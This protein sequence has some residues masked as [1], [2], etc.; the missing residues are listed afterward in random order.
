M[1]TTFS[2]SSAAIEDG[3]AYE[4]VVVGAGPAGLQA[5]YFLRH[6][7][8]SYVVVDGA[9]GPGS[10][11]RTCPRGRTL[12]SINK[13]SFPDLGGDIDAAEF[14]LRHDW[15]SLLSVEREPLMAAFSKAYYP[16]A[17]DLVRYLEAFEA[18][19]DLGVRYGWRCARVD[20]RDDGFAVTVER[21][22]VSA[23]VAASVVLVA[24]GLGT[25]AAPDPDWTWRARQRVDYRD[26]PDD[27]GCYAGCNVGV[28]GGGNSAR[29]AR[30]L[31]R[32]LSRSD[33]GLVLW[34]L[35]WGPVAHLCTSPLDTYD[36][37]LK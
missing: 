22:G 21:D 27:L 18:R 23:T 12:I 3:A 14:R 7:G 6:F 24:A 11:F 34:L 28:V 9:D 37:M 5:A 13:T 8:L 32:P 17:D 20:T 33:R 15:N 10:F 29:D 35:P 30:V 36:V 2:S 1:G 4:Y 25:P 16:D 19:H 26:L 31:W